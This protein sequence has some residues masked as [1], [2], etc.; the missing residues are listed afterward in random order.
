MGQGDTMEVPSSPVRRAK[1]ARLCSS[2]SSDAAVRSFFHPSSQH[3]D[4]CPWVSSEEEFQDDGTDKEPGKAVP[5]W[6][7]V[8]RRLLGIRKCD[9]VPEAE[10]V[11]SGSNGNGAQGVGIGDGRALFGVST[12][13]AGE[14]DKVES[15]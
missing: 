8:L 4:W 2:S 1:R 10:P 3:R 9:T 14:K 12:I 7:L 11:V 13:T 15:L 6:E 5:G